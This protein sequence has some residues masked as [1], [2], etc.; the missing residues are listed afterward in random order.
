MAI[1]WPFFHHR[2]FHS[3]AHFRPVLEPTRVR[4]WCEFRVRFLKA[5][6]GHDFDVFN[7]NVDHKWERK[8]WTLSF[9][10]C[11]NFASWLCFFWGGILAALAAPWPPWSPRLPWPSWVLSAPRAH[12]LSK[13]MLFLTRIEKHEFFTKTCRNWEGFRE[14]SHAY[15]GQHTTHSTQHT[16]QSTRHRAH[17][18]QCTAHST[19]TLGER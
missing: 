8:A 13:C 19:H 9:G 2:V 4:F 10:F 15:C 7:L 3:R 6:F 1:S 11:P 12:M 14:T 16:A 18:A 5:C 17:S